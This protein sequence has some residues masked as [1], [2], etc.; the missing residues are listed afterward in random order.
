M[1]RVCLDESQKHKLRG[2]PSKI[3]QNGVAFLTK[4]T[5]TAPPPDQ[6]HTQSR[7]IYRSITL[8]KSQRMINKI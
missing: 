6:P 5:S 8:K 7:N 2:K 3:I 1:Q 4:L